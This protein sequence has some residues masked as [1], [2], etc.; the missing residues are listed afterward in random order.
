[1]KVKDLKLI[2]EKY[3]LTGEQ[4]KKIERFDEE[5]LTNFLKT[6]TSSDITYMDSIIKVIEKRKEISPEQL[7]L[8][9]NSVTSDVANT[10]ADFINQ[11]KCSMSDESK[12]EL[13]NY[14]NGIEYTEIGIEAMKIIWQMAE[15]GVTRTDEKKHVIL[16]RIMANCS[17]LEKLTYIKDFLYTLYPTASFRETIDKEVLDE[18]NVESDI[19]SIM[20]QCPIEKAPY[21]FKV[22]SG[23]MHS[24]R[25]NND[26]YDRFINTLDTAA[27]LPSIKK[28]E[29]AS[30]CAS[31]FVVPKE[32]RQLDYLN[33]IMSSESI[34]GAECMLRILKKSTNYLND[35]IYETPELLT[36]IKLIG[37]FDGEDIYRLFGNKL[38]KEINKNNVPA[39]LYMVKHRDGHSTDYKLTTTV[40]SVLE[41][42]ENYC[43]FDE[44]YEEDREAA[45]EGLK[46]L[47]ESFP[48]ME[49]T[50]NKT[51]VKR[52]SNNS[53]DSEE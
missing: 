17:D 41:D 1:M 24:T 15:A 53:N 7:E 10:F 2:L 19:I 32:D 44:L 39:A 25:I 37:S 47:G 35:T 51:Y 42:K 14:V 43:L 46:E 8:L 40:L 30:N 9:N 52:I 33:A 48:D 27:N 4:I 3:N 26:N 20:T 11:T 45:I 5:Q 38:R 29:I 22:L 50:S 23:L 21:L 18:H 49:F 12:L 13:M 28:L 36:L 34:Q 31:L 16:G 6:I